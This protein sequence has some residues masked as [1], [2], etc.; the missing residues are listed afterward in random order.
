[1]NFSIPAVLQYCWSIPPY[2][3]NIQ[4]GELVFVGS[5]EWSVFEKQIFIF[6][7]C[8]LSLAYFSWAMKGCSSCDRLKL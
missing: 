6:L 2:R 8:E 7:Y 4:D 1:M 5:L 3:V